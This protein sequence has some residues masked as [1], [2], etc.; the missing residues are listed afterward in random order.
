MPTD[1]PAGAAPG[2]AVLDELLASVNRLIVTPRPPGGYPLEWAVAA[3]FAGDVGGIA[4]LS[5]RAQRS[6]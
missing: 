4:A 6:S 2:A 3:Y 1:E 5:I